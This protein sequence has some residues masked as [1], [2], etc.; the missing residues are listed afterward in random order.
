MALPFI[1]GIALGA[2]AVVAF[3]KSDKLKNKVEEV[4]DKSKDLA[5]SSLEKGKVVVNDITSS[6]KS[7]C[8]KEEPEVAVATATKT[9][10]KKRV[11]RTKV[12]ED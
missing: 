12:K 7:T 1:L 5:S 6:I 9:V 3:N 11:R 2:S 8:S 4:F 10:A